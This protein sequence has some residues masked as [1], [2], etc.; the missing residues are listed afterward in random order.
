MADIPR[1]FFLNLDVFGLKR[2][3][4]LRTSGR[5]DHRLSVSFFQAYCN[6]KII[7]TPQTSQGPTTVHKI[8]LDNCQATRIS[9]KS[10]G[11]R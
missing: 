7:Q 2:N 1:Q 9:R 8:L 11:S 5:I 3:W 4:S 6:R 10:Y